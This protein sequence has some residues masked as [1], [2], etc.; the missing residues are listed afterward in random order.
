MAL[1][2][3]KCTRCGQSFSAGDWNC[4]DGSAHQITAKVYYVNDAPSNRKDEQ[5][6]RSSRLIMA[7]VVP[8]QKFIRNN[9]VVQVPGINVEFIRGMLST[10]DP[11][12]Q[13]ALDQRSG[14]F[15]GDEGKKI[16]GD[17]YLTGPEK[18]EIERNKLMADNKRLENERN[19]LLAKVKAESVKPEPPKPTEK[20][21]I[22]G[23]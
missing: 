6:M 12:I 21:R 4:K 18:A 5:A 19:E 20:P 3:W 13:N 1:S 2:N 7:N 14:V 8:E 11:K 10:T 9:D 17:A 15:Q 23:G 16:W 22:L